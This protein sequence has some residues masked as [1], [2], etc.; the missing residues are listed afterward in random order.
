MNTLIEP[1]FIVEIALQNTYRE[2]TDQGAKNHIN[3]KT[4]PKC[5]ELRIIRAKN[6]GGPDVSS[7]PEAHCWLCRLLA[8]WTVQTSLYTYKSVLTTYK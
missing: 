8:W 3:I 7:K 6:P 4:Y 1:K 5:M 2:E